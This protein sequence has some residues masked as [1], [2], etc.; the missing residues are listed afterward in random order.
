MYSFHCWGVRPPAVVH[1][2]LMA[3]WTFRFQ[4]RVV[5]SA[6]PLA[7]VCPLGLNATE[8]MNPAPAGKSDGRDSY[9]PSPPVTGD[10]IT[11]SASP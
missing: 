11:P 7:I 1:I 10:G 8:E 5:P 9:R 4:S 6:L 2:R 3:Y